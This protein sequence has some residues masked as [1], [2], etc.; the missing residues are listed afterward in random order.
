MS[1]E[2]RQITLENLK[3][4]VGK[5]FNADIAEWFYKL[6]R[7]VEQQQLDIMNFFKQ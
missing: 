2:R 3:F 4:I 5:H 1:N 6:Y 7:N